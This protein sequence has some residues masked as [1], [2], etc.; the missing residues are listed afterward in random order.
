M[1]N[2]LELA[3]VNYEHGGL[4]ADPAGL[5]LHVGEG[6]RYEHSRLARL[7]G[8]G[9]R[10]P[11]LAVIGECD[12]WEFWAGRGAWEAIAAIAEAGG[13]S[14]AW[15]PTVL[16]REWGPFAPGIL[17]DPQT[18]RVQRYFS[19]HA[20][21]FAA[22][23][24]NLLVFRHARGSESFFLVP[25]H[26]DPYVP[27]HRAMD[28][29]LL[30]WLANEKRSSILL[31]DFNEPLD[32]PE[33]QPT[34]LDDPTIYDKPWGSGAKIHLDHGRIVPPRRR[35]TGSLDYLCGWWDPETQQRVHGIGFTDLAELHNITTPTDLR[36]PIG[37]PGPGRE[38]VALD[39][40]LVNGRAREFVQMGSFRV[41][42][43][44]D[45]DNPDSDHK[46]LSVTLAA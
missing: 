14:Y 44:I 15:L 9:G 39:H 8:D 5:G 22:R 12:R 38:G 28:A 24:R 32:G 27:G 16:P 42:E 33:Y 11:D 43:P 20:P 10:W 18:V 23:T 4:I 31:G 21:D 2:E 25:I 41:H 35:S 13:R 6:Y 34:D 3:Y 46:R 29:Q 26:G 36:R 40:I 30:W 37:T 19:P 45:P 7:F 17:Y 1:I